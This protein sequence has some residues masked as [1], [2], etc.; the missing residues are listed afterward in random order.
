MGVTQI[1]ILIVLVLSLGIAIGRIASK[2]FYKYEEKQA[3][4]NVKRIIKAAKTEAARLKR[5]KI[6]ETKERFRRL[7]AEFEQSSG[8]KK[9]DY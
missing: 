4:Q 6:L 1:F 8:K 5:E 3:E 9:K 7:K 2:L